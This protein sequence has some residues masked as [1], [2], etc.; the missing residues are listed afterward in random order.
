[1]LA[2]DGSVPGAGSVLSSIVAAEASVSELSGELARE[3][4]STLTKREAVSAIVTRKLGHPRPPSPN[5]SSALGMQVFEFSQ[6]YYK[7]LT[8]KAQKDA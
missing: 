6:G 1:M 3:W 4:Q 7:Q 8:C 2:G 5:P